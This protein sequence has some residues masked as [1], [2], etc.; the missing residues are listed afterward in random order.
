MVAAVKIFMWCESAAA[1]VFEMDCL[2]LG[3][4]A[5]SVQKS[6][7]LVNGLSS[8]CQN[9]T[10]DAHRCGIRAVFGIILDE[11]EGMEMEFDEL[12][13]RISAAIG[14]ELKAEDGVCGV[15]VDG[16]PMVVR[17]IPEHGIALL[18]ADLGDPPPQS[19]AHLYRVLLE[20][21]HAFRGTAGATL[22]I[23][24]RNGHVCL[25]HYFKLELFEESLVTDRFSGFANAVS[26]W[27]G[28]LSSYRPVEEFPDASNLL[29]AFRV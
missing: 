13:D 16:V 1:G 25:Q 5:D 10:A 11:S 6:L 14:V 2:L 26:A 15:K 24:P 21:N 18:D 3:L 8:A 19:E 17:H 27:R 28:F 22:S 4:A 9:A 12:V 23:N 7:R 29:G 20:S